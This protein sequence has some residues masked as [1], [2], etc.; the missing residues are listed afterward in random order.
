[1]DAET[2]YDLIEFGR[3]FIGIIYLSG[4]CLTD[5]WFWGLI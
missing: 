1:M 5:S 4:C 3:A 2:K